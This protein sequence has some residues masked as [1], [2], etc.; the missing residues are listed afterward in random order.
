[1]DANQKK[2]AAAISGVLAYIKTEEEILCAQRMG[3]APAAGFP[4]PLPAPVKLWGV[5]GRQ[6]QMQ[7]RNLMQLRSFKGTHFR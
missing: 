1:M 6:Q 7:L 2:I 3:A 4:V 5:S